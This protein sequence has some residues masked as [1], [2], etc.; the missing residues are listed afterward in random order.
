MSFEIY[1]K[2]KQYFIYGEGQFILSPRVTD[3]WDC[4]GS[5]VSEYVSKLEHRS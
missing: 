5:F 3:L 2:L 4:F 1:D